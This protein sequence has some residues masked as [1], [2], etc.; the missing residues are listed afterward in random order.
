M[1]PLTATDRRRAS[2]HEMERIILSRVA[3]GEYPMG[4]RLP[5]CERLGR[6]LGA[7]KNTIS[8]AY[9]ALARQGY[10]LSRPGRGTFVARRPDSAW[11][12][13]KATE[14]KKLLGDAILQAS[15]SGL[16]ADELEALALEAIRLHFKRGTV[17]VGYVDCNRLD[18]RELGRELEAALSSPV[19]P[20]VVA[21]LVADMLRPEDSF[22]VLAVNLAHLGAVE[23]RLGRV[24]GNRTAVVPIVALPDAETL[25][26][27][28]RLPAG[29]RL[30]VISDTEEVLHTLTG[31]ARGV[32]PSAQVSALLS[33][34]PHLETALEEADVALATR[35]A[36]RRVTAVRRGF[37]I[38]MA[39]F[40]LDEQSVLELAERM[41]TIRH[42]GPAPEPIPERELATASPE[43]LPAR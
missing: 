11:D 41:A 32:N 39:S 10:T 5:T 15:L 22:D 14:V 42:A 20:L 24:R 2:V 13:D 28:A 31:L 37:P 18:A 34:D 17:R 8:K 23:R 19:E 35:T 12:D 40:K 3:R 36:H 9:Q 1:S 29:T 30:L 21:D 6:E 7:N 26:Q 4:S 25:T 43:Q 38:I 33:S 27:V 16:S